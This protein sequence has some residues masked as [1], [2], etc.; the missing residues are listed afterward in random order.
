MSDHGLGIAVEYHHAKGCGE[1]P[2]GGFAANWRREAE[3]RC[4]RGLDQRVIAP[5]SV[6]AAMKLFKAT[7]EAYSG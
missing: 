1:L 2:I 7:M 5:F 3:T 4:A 6:L